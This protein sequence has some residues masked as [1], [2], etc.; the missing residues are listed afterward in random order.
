MGLLYHSY[1]GPFEIFLTRSDHRT[2]KI[3]TEPNRTEIVSIIRS[4]WIGLKRTNP[5]LSDDHGGSWFI[6]EIRVY[7]RR[8]FTSG[9]EW[10]LRCRFLHCA[11]CTTRTPSHTWS[12][13][14]A[15][16]SSSTVVGTTSSTLPSSNLSPGSS[17]YYSLLVFEIERFN[18]SFDSSV[19]FFFWSG[20]LLP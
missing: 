2:C 9:E 16:T 14:M 11:E 1:F 10:V 17:P 5:T 18:L 20:L 4:I 13:S 15:S 6:R 19:F 7:H 3:L 8:G 12:P